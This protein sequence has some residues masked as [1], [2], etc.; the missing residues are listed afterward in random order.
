MKQSA[1]VTINDAAVRCRCFQSL[2][3]VRTVRPRDRL[4][5][6]VTRISRLNFVARKSVAP[7]LFLG[8]IQP[9][10]RSHKTL[11]YALANVA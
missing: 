2:S 1:T 4:I 10:A 3:A 7:E 11:N 9:P 5:L 8:A 6:G